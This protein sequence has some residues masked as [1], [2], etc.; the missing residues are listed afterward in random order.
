MFGSA[1]SRWYLESWQL[2]QEFKLPFTIPGYL[3]TYQYM[4]EHK[5]T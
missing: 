1:I 4:P 2:A 5:N 3:Y